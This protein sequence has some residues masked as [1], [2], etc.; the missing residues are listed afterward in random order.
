MTTSDAT[1]AAY[2]VEQIHITADKLRT[3]WSWLQ[4]LAEPGRATAPSGTAVDDQKA[5]RL[6]AIGRSDRAY[7]DYNLRHGMSALPP[8]PAPIRIGIVDAQVAVHG[9]ITTAVRLLA[10]TGGSAHTWARADAA[11]GSV[12]AALDW[13]V[14]YEVGLGVSGRDGVW[15]RQGAVDRIRDAQ[16]AADVDRILQRADRAARSAAGDNGSVVRPL[17]HRCP[18]CGRRSLQLEVTSADR[19]DW[20]ARCVSERCR[21]TGPGEPG[22]PACGCLRRLSYDV[23]RRH[24]W[25]YGQLDGRAGL[26]AALEMYDRQQPGVGSGLTGRG[27]WQSTSQVPFDAV[28]RRAREIAEERNPDA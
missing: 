23:G 8:S 26:L 24:V 17:E 22:V 14:G 25:T 10:G 5:E 9:L 16:L 6:E 3:A 1:A 11:L 12:P 27:G 4:L 19:R 20:M 18:A 2:I 21:C 15:I 13:L 7:R 28:L